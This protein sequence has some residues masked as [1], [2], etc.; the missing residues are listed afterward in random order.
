MFHMEASHSHRGDWVWSLIQSWSLSSL[1]GTS[2]LCGI[3]SSWRALP[4]DTLGLCCVG[5][6]LL[7]T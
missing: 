4:Q 2:F 3:E 5:P 6:L 1:Y 7:V